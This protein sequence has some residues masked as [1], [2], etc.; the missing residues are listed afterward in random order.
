MVLRSSNRHRLRVVS[1]HVI[2][3]FIQII[4]K[5]TFGGACL[6]IHVYT[7]VGRENI[8]HEFGEVSSLI[9]ASGICPWAVQPIRS[10]VSFGLSYLFLMFPIS[11]GAESAYLI[12]GLQYLKLTVPHGKRSCAPLIGIRETMGVFR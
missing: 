7:L 12:C 10:V 4:A 6:V 2:A 8:M 1:G 11:A 9:E 5:R 3:F